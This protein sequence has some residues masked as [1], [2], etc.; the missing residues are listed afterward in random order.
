M[1]D[2]S[3]LAEERREEYMSIAKDGPMIQRL[4]TGEEQRSNIGSIDSYRSKKQLNRAR[5]KEM[6]LYETLNETQLPP[7]ANTSKAAIEE[8]W[9]LEECFE[10]VKHVLATHEGLFEHVKKFHLNSN[11]WIRMHVCCILFVNGMSL[12]TD[13]EWLYWNILCRCQ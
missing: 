5:P 4:K 2:A 7:E 12:Q 11:E 6:A 8:E 3:A 9:S 13:I 1:S 10:V